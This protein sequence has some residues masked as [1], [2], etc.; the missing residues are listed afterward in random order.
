[1]ARVDN[2]PVEMWN[3][4]ACSKCA[5]ARET[6]EG[7]GVPVRL[8]AY[9]EQPPTAAELT[10]VLDRLHAQPWDICRLGEPVAQELGLEGWARDE[11]TRGK[12]IEAMVS[13]PQLIQ[14]PIVLLDDGSAMVART[15]QA[16][17]ELAAKVHTG[18]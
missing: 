14:R 16:L 5:A 4:P 1:M 3:N 15:P 6:L 8:R 11:N 18:P 10:A 13:H 9:L 7:L 12:W 2:D 17:S